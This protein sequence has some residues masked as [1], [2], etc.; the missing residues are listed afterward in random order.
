MY[1]IYPASQ[2]HQ[3]SGLAPDSGIRITKNFLL[4]HV[5]NLASIYPS[6]DLTASE[7]LTFSL[8][9]VELSA[10]FEDNFRIV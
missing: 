6:P 8:S 9:T 5:F 10:S 3:S 1:T 4:N 7:A 2:F